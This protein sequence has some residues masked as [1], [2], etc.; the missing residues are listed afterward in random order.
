[1]SVRLALLVCSIVMLYPPVPV[2][3]ASGDAASSPSIAASAGVLRAIAREQLTLMQAGQASPGGTAGSQ[4]W[5]LRSPNADAL[6]AAKLRAS[7]AFDPDPLA[8]H[9]PSAPAPSPQAV[10]RV[11]QPGVS[12]IEE[13]WC[14]TPP[15]TTGAIGPTRYLEMVNNLVAVHDRNLNRLSQLDLASF[16]GAPGGLN[17]TDPQI[18]WDPQGNRWLYAA[19]AFATHN[20]FLVL[21]WSKTD[22]PSDLAGGWCRFGL[23]TGNNLNDYPKLGH[24]DTFLTIGT[25][26]FDDTSGTFVFTTANIWAVPKPDVGDASC[27]PPEAFAFADAANPLRNADGTLAV[28]PVAANT[29]DNSANGYVVAA[30]TPVGAGPQTKCSGQEIR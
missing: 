17:L 1:M 23:F 29:S 7:A 27:T 30:H 15:D 10:V 6:R 2:S 26:V 14:C 20:N 19:L 25:N 5:P 16:V 4:P 18:Q 28:T 22:D 9:T 3:A 8:P 13:F 11:N 12:V 21:G 24:D